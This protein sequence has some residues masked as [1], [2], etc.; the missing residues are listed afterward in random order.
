[1]TDEQKLWQTIDQALS[2]SKEPDPHVIARR[3]LPR[4][5]EVQREEAL[6]K[7]LVELVTERIRFER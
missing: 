5:S 3:L 1:M 6:M 4:L 2:K 7:V